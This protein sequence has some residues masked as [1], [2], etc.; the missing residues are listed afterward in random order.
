M[1]DGEQIRAL[2]HAYAERLDGGD[3]DGVAELFAD[4][5]WR[6]G[7][8][9]E[10]FR[11]VEQVR[12]MYRG[13]VLYGGKPNTKH[14]ITNVSVTI[15]G[16][17]AATARSYF[18]VLQAT[19]DLP[20]QPIIAGSYEDAFAREDGTWRFSDRLIIVDLVG[21]LSHHMRMGDAT[22]ERT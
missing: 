5:T 14:V 1:D 3:L 22:P 7:G 2:I 21:D 18:T 4:A 9:T 12:K 19:P 8:R 10:V 20:L 15:D 6:S 16:S 13:V 17:D 11:G